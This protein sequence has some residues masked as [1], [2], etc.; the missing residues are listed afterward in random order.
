MIRIAATAATQDPS[1]WQAVQLQPGVHEQEGIVD[2]QTDAQ[3]RL[4]LLTRQGKLYQG[5]SDKIT[6]RW[7]PDN[8]LATGYF[9][10][11]LPVQHLASVFLP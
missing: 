5:E 10:C 8:A 9:Q 3:Q 7:Q 4:W 11:M 2:I 6:L 1:S